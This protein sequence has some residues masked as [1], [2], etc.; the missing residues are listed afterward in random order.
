MAVLRATPRM[1]DG[2]SVMGEAR[3]EGSRRKVGGEGEVMVEV[4]PSK[5]G[6]GENVCSV[7]CKR[8]R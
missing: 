2:V 4:Y 3:R 7:G 1:C 8:I 5:P 6:G